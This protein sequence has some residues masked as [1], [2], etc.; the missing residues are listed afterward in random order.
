VKEPRGYATKWIEQLMPQFDLADEDILALRTFLASR[1]EQRVPPKYAYRSAV[2]Q[3]VVAGRNLVSRY[4]CTGCHV[5][6]GKGGDVRR[7]YQEQPSMAPPLLASEGEKVQA[8]W[9]FSF[10]KA[11]SPIRPWLH[12]RMPTFGLSDQEAATLV[13]YFG[14]L[15]RVDVPFVHLEK[16]SFSPDSIEAGRV[17]M[18]R[19]YLDCFNCH[20]QGDRKPQGPPD[21][22]A[23]DLAMAAHRLNPEWIVKW[24]YDPQKI[25]PGTKMPSFYPDPNAPDGPPDILGGDD[26]A[27]IR[28]M[29]DY[30][31]WLGLPDAPAASGQMAQAGAPAR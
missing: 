18:S 27:Q 30:I 23:P 16:A 11:P 22:W 26:D 4:N 14:G 5:I 9:L 19:D 17:L 2:E 8:D 15:D 12:I 3:Q 25:M 24:L 31:M 13:A 29:R 7:L 28:A 10:V 1:T 21:G 20:Q 6:E